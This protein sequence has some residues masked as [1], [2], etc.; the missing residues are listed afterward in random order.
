MR[1]AFVLML[2]VLASSAFALGQPEISASVLRYEPTPAEQGNTVDVWV[3]LTNRGTAA[4]NVAVRF[5]PEYP[6]SLVDGPA[7]VDVG[8]LA[9]TEQKVVKFTL[10]VDPNAPNGEQD[11]KF[12]YKYS[13]QDAWVGLEHPIMVETQDAALVVEAYSVVPSPVIPGQDARLVISLM[14]AGKIGIKNLDVSLDLADTHF[15][16]IASSTHKRVNYVGPGQLTNVTYVLASG[17]ETEVKLYDIPVK[18][19]FQDERNKRYEESSKIG[20]R[21]NAPPEI[22]LVVDGTDFQSKQS[23]GDVRLKLVN[24]GVTDIKYVTLTLLPSAEYELLSSSAEAYLGNL[25]NDDFETAEWKIRPLSQDPRLRVRLEF[26][27]PFNQDFSQEYVLP[28]RIVTPEELGE[29]GSSMLWVILVLVAIGAAWWW[30][31]RKR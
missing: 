25:D 7:K 24:K 6:F 12:E 3:Q 16:P 1:I 13:M 20:I 19:S 22:S 9:A 30:R 31:K 29:G 4:D 11:V 17:T 15:S 14:N 21:V 18:L 2:L 28:L 10:F 26:K 23:P 5:K 8:I 27:D